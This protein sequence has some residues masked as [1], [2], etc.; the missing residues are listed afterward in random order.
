[1][2]ETTCG[3]ILRKAQPR[4]RSGSEKAR[5]VSESGRLRP[6]IIAH[7]GERKHVV[8]L[9][10][11]QNVHPKSRIHAA[12]LDSRCP[13]RFDVRQ[14]GR[15]P[16]RDNA[17]MF[18]SRV[19]A[20]GRELTVRPITV[21][22]EP[23]ERR[24]FARL[25]PR[26]LRLRFHKWANA[27]NEGLIRFYTHIDQDRHLAFV[28]EHAGEIVGEARCVAHPGGASCELGIVVADDWHHTGIAQLLMR[29]LIDAARA[30][31]YGSIEGLVL[32]E[33][34]DML[35]FVKTLGFDVEPMAQEP[36]TVR[37][38]KRL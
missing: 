2:T 21:R 14:L 20:D 19:L 17:P 13:P 30:H 24:F 1:M 8:G 36:G 29:V 25:S 23:A 34:A 35:E 27:V 15:G 5:V 7:R 33:N 11:V 37:V 31:G 6:A 32:A 12:I 9:E 22:D 4:S 28:C 10:H 26:T 3:T 38:L 18:P 16:G